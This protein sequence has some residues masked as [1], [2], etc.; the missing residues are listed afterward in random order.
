MEIRG[1][2]RIATQCSYLLNVVE[3][4]V[5]VHIGMTVIKINIINYKTLQVLLTKT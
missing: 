2:E 5:R 1:I 3:I 4:G